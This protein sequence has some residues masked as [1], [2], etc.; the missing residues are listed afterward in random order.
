MNIEK[1]KKGLDIGLLAVVFIAMIFAI[2]YI[3]NEIEIQE[4]REEEIEKYVEANNLYVT[5]TEA[6]IR[7]LEYKMTVDLPNNITVKQYYNVTNTTTPPIIYNYTNY[8][9]NLSENYNDNYG[10]V[11]V[12]NNNYYDTNRTE[13][14]NGYLQVWKIEPKTF[15]YSKL[16][17]NKSK[18]YSYYI[19]NESRF[20]FFIINH[21]ADYRILWGCDP[22]NNQGYSDMI[23]FDENISI[24]QSPTYLV[25]NMNNWYFLNNHGIAIYEQFPQGDL[26]VELIK[27]WG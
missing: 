25:I 1:I 13:I 26:L 22:N 6:Y 9:Y 3:N 23:F 5:K 4:Q 16:I 17:V 18:P 15:N 19:D 20:A 10:N 24:Y 27:F 12:I 11:S 7:Y 2:V 8:T 21:T 14:I